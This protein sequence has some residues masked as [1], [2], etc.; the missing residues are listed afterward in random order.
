MRHTDLLSRGLLWNMLKT[1]VSH[2]GVGSI[3]ERFSTTTDDW[4]VN[5]LDGTP[6][7]SHHSRRCESS[8]SDRCKCSC[9]G[10]L[11]GS[12][13][14]K[15]LEIPGVGFNYKAAFVAL[16]S[17]LHGQAM[18]NNLLSVMSLGKVVETAESAGGAAIPGYRPG[19][20]RSN[21]NEE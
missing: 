10:M 8:E 13:N 19:R 1:I 15:Q 9:A 18:R 6:A 7:K 12:S 2:P 20:S 5:P 16:F 4:T 3:R 14:Q 11:H 17:A 21:S